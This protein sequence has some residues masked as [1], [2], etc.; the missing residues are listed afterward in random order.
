MRRFLAVGPAG[1]AVAEGV[2]GGS[3][4]MTRYCFLVSVLVLGGCE[5]SA[6]A[7]LASA[8][9]QRSAVVPAPAAV[10]ASAPAIAPSVAPQLAAATMP[11]GVAKS[12]GASQILVKRLVVTSGIEDRE[13]LASVQALPSD[14]TAIYAFAELSNPEGESENV[15]IT[16]ERQGGA[17][18]VGNVT[19]PVPGKVVRH[20]TWATTRFIRAPGVWEAVLWSESGSELGRVSFEVT[21]A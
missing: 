13:P 4:T 19:L 3:K 15:R 14:G 1:A 18:R 9:P 5:V 10:S 2:T 6:P 21:S 20:R 11:R 16:F 12:P 7:T 8:T 17:E